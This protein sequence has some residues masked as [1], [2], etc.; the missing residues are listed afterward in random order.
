MNIPIKDCIGKFKQIRAK[1]QFNLRSI[2][3]LKVS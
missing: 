2:P 3:N 1:A